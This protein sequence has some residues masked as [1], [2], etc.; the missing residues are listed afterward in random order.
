MDTAYSGFEGVRELRASAAGMRAA[1]AGVGLVGPLERFRGLP[2]GGSRPSVRL[3]AEGHVESDDNG[4][5]DLEQIFTV[6]VTFDHDR[7]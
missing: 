6:P 4:P 7:S 5:V 3:S 1:I 2:F